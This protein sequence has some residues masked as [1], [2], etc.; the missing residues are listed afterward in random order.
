MTWRTWLCQ[1][2]NHMNKS[3]ISRRYDDTITH[4]FN[5][6]LKMLMDSRS[7]FQML[8]KLNGPGCLTLL[9]AHMFK[10]KSPKTKRN[11]PDHG[12]IPS[13]HRL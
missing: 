8:Q 2:I 6:T 3:W 11:I 1:R 13:C 9:P 5:A 7:E 4:E 10:E 12:Y